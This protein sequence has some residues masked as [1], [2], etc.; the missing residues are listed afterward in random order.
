MVENWKIENS[1]IWDILISNKFSYLRNKI[2]INFLCTI[3]LFYL[4][5]II[6]GIFTYILFNNDLYCYFVHRSV[7]I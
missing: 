4:G 3:Y 6:L 1:N 5:N 2:P 7:I